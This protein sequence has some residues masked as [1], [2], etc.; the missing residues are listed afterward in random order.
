MP[1]FTPMVINK[2]LA[3]GPDVSFYQDDNGTPRGIDFNKMKSAGASFVII[4]A[5]QNTWADP[6]F[7]ENWKNANMAGMPRG[8]Y[9]YLDVRASMR[10]QAKIYADLLRSDPGEIVP[11]V[12]FE[13][14]AI[15]DGKKLGVNDLQ[16]FLV[17]FDEYLKLDQKL[18][19]YTGPYFWK[20]RGS[21]DAKWR[22]HPLWIANY[23]VSEPVVPAPWNGYK[24]WQFTESGP[25][26]E[27]GVESNAIDMNYLRGELPWINK[28]D[29]VDP[30]ITPT[31][32]MAVSITYNDGS[33]QTINKETT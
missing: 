17:Y 31:A 9:W 29:P 10:A 14:Q 20:E 4:R 2:D 5:G 12:D 18:M 19:V 27:Y 30:P 3:H 33:K 23:K 21:T 22:Q 26:K 15:Y 7:A 32:R 13:Q 8:A 6:D 1:L 25:G 28:P 16:A 11:T 24:L